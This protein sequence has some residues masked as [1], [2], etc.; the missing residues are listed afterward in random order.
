MHLHIYKVSRLM[1]HIKL[2]SLY[3]VFPI[4]WVRTNFIFTRF[5]P[6][7][8]LPYSNI[9]MTVC[10]KECYKKG[11]YLHFPNHHLM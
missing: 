3:K 1:F 6:L 5:T 2:A 10:P 11:I 4:S 8:L 9:I 7:Y